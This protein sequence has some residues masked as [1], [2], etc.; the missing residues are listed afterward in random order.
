MQTT[1]KMD[2]I[3]QDLLPLPLNL[4]EVLLSHMYVFVCVCVVV[5]TKAY[6]FVI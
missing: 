2:I 5:V 4:E 3:N 1:T 6:S